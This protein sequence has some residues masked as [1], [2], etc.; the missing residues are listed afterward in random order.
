[1]PFEA[2]VSLCMQLSSVSILAVTASATAASFSS[3]VLSGSSSATGSPV[4]GPGSA[5]GFPAIYSTCHKTK[6][7]CP[8]DSKIWERLYVPISWQW[9]AR[10][11]NP[12]VAGDRC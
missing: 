11:P 7:C 3:A 2:G 9:A 12:E 8:L 10:L 6:V 5:V 4:F 1:M